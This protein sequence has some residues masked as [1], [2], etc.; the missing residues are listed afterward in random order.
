MRALIFRLLL[1]ISI[2]FEIIDVSAED[3]HESSAIICVAG[4][5]ELSFALLASSKW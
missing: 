1:D 4:C 3:K 5:V 2:F